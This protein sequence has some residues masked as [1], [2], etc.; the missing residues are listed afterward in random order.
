MDMFL[1]YDDVMYIG[2]LKQ[3]R[4]WYILKYFILLV[5]IEETLRGS[6]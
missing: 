5:Q 3:G 6:S 4:E 2:C 1:F